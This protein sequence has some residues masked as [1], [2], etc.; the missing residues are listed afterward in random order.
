MADLSLLGEASSALP[1]EI[2]NSLEQVAP[3]KT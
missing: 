1:S 3:E 2:A